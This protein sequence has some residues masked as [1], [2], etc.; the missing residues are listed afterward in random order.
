MKYSHCKVAAVYFPQD[1]CLKTALTLSLAEHLV[2]HR[3]KRVGIVDLTHNGSMGL[4]MTAITP[5]VNIPADFYFCAVQWK[6]T[7]LYY[8]GPKCLRQALLANKSSVISEY[9]C[10]FF[11]F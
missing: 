10:F 6:T 4:D 3:R 7:P 2:L 8:L 9:F 5:D 11:S 1:K